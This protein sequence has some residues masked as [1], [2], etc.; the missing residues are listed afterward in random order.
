MKIIKKLSLVLLSSLTGLCL[1]FVFQK[2]ND[3]LEVIFFD[4]GQGDSILILSPYGQRILIDGGPDKKVLE[5]LSRELG[6]FEKDLDLIILSHP[7][8]DHIVGLY[9][10]IKRYQTERL[11][12]FSPGSPPQR[13]E[14][15]LLLAQKQEIKS[16]KLEMKE[17]WELG[18]NC[19]LENYPPLRPSKD[20]NTW[21]IITSLDCL[22]HAFLFLGDTPAKEEELFFKTVSKN[23]EV[24][25]I[26]HHGSNYSSSQNFISNLNP[27]LAI[28]SVGKNKFGHPGKRVLDLL[29]EFKVPFLRTDKQGQI[30]L[31]VFGEKLKI[32][33]ER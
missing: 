29:E 33:T 12:Y 10:V 13:L 26:S 3:S 15:F 1:I 17:S 24:L 14:N 27:S 19:F 9:E 22:G 21:S 23:Y 2:Q 5:S 18:P 7:H 4:V 20:Q 25:K 31:Q 30:T 11:L 16:E 32:K 6:P 28:I 8:D